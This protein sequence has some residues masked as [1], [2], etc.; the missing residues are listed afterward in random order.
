MKLRKLIKK[1][2]E[3]YEQDGN[4]RVVLPQVGDPDSDN[5]FYWDANISYVEAEGNGEELIVRIL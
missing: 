4:I 2:L 3:I 1:L 5:P